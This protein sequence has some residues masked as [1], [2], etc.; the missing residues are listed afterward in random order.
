MK[1]HP[2]VSSFACGN[3]VLKKKNSSM[4]CSL[5]SNLQN[6][7]FVKQYSQASFVTN[8]KTQLFLTDYKKSFQNPLS[9][10]GIPWSI[11][12]S[13]ISSVSDA[14][15]AFDYLKLGNYLDSNDDDICPK[16][17]EIRK[18]NLSF[19]DEIHNETEKKDLL[20]ITVI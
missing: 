16:N 15:R 2:I 10:K 4:S 8:K 5:N 7:M 3:F 1:I 9:F 12:V 19:L 13:N 18:Q 11:P 20:N 6:D 17:K 14:I